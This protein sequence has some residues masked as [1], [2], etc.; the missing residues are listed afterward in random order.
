M[1]R[2]EDSE[3]H[4]ASRLEGQLGMMGIAELLEAFVCAVWGKA[5][6]TDAPHPEDKDVDLGI[7]GTG[8]GFAL[9][10]MFFP[11]CALSAGASRSCWEART[12]DHAARSQPKLNASRHLQ[13]P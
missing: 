3:I 8:C 9:D 12:E 2:R 4:L 13:H 6:R 7:A 1:S 5:E 10:P 11:Q